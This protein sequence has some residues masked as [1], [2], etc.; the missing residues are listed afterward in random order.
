MIDWPD[1]TLW[2]KGPVG[3]LMVSTR[4]YSG[5]VLNPMTLMTDDG[6][7]SMIPVTIDEIEIGDPVDP[8]GPKLIDINPIEWYCDWPNYWARLD[9]YLMTHTVPIIGPIIGVV[10]VTR[11]YLLT[12]TVTGWVDYC[13][14]QDNDPGSDPVVV[15][16]QLTQ[17]KLLMDRPIVDPLLTRWLLL[18]IID[19]CDII[20]VI[21]WYCWFIGH[22]PYCYWCVLMTDPLCWLLLL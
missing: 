5:C 1:P 2:L 4:Y 15:W 19:Y 10:E 8:V 6:P 22:W 3:P 18:L 14:W 12:R 17:L 9:S 16:T 11:T 20:V 13:V 7:D 21:N